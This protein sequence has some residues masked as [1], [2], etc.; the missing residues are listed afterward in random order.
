MLLEPIRKD[1][2]LISI[3]KNPPTKNI[4]DVKI[5]SI[6]K[7]TNNTGYTFN[8]YISPSNNSDI[9]QD[10]ILFDKEIMKSIENNS[11]KW[12]NRQFNIR[13]ITEL[14]NKSFCN[15]TKTM[16]V[17]LTNKQI[18]N[19]V[20]NNNVLKDIED[21]VNILIADNNS[22]NNTNKSFV[23]I[24]IEYYGLYIYS[25]STSNKW[26]IK[27]ID[28]SNIS[29]DDNTVSNEELIENFQHRIYNIKQK[30]NDKITELGKNI[31]NIRNNM[32]TIDE[33]LDNLKKDS[34]LTNNNIN[35]C[36]SKLNTLILTQE[37]NIK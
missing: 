24:T 21:I 2:K 37:E 18:R 27:T 28:I 4:V 8:I 23:N 35:Y 11:L 30:C 32:K 13:E 3:Y 33:L 9:I 31:D 25:E 20:Y 7:L 36:L 19:M 34:E 10:L 17:I 12:F 1:K 22:D 15:Q 26:I 29:D 5:K 14:Y 16:S 6:N